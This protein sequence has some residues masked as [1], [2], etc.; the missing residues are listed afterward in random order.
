MKIALFLSLLTLTA[1]AAC[2]D[3]TATTQPTNNCVGANC[4][5]PCTDTS[6]CPAETFCDDDG[7]CQ[8]QICAPLS[9]GC[10]GNFVVT[11]NETGSAL[12]DPTACDNGT[13]IAG[14]C[15]CI[16]DTDCGEGERCDTVELCEGEDCQTRSF[17]RIACE[18]NV[19]GF[20]GE[21]CCTGD[22]PTCGPAGE[23]APDCG[24]A[25]LCGEDF[26]QCCDPGDVCI[27]GACK[28]PGI[29][30]Q[31]FLE[32]SW[33]E[34]CD[35]GLQRCLPDDFPEE[36][37]CRLEGDFR[38]FQVDE[39]WS[40][41]DGDIIS[42]PVVGDVT[43]DGVPNIVVN[44]TVVNDWGTGQIVI[45]DSAGNLVREIAHDPMA[46]S[47]GSF[48]RSNIALGDVDGDGVL[49][50]IYPGRH[51]NAGKGP[52]VA[53][54][55]LGDLLWTSKDTLGATV[56]VSMGN[57]AVT[58]AN[59]D[60]DASRTEVVVG[61]ML[62]DS[63]GVVQWNETGNGPSLGSNSGYFGGIAVVADLDADGQHEIIT[64]RQAW[65]VIENAGTFSVTPFWTS[66][67]GDGYPA[68]AD[69]DG[70]GKPEVVLVSAGTVRILNG[71]TGLPWC[72]AGQDCGANPALLTQ[73][74]A[75]PGAP[76]NNR[77]GPPT[78]ADFDGD[79]RPEIG[80][81]GGYFYS[82][83]DVARAG[84]AGTTDP[85]E[86]D[87]A[88]L[89]QFETPAPELNQLFVRW[90]RASQDLSSNATGSSV[91]DFQGNGIASVIYADECYMRSF[92]GVD[93]T[94]ELEIMNSTATVLEYPL[95]VDIDAD[96]RSEILIVANAASNCTAIPD[97]VPRR[98]LYVYEDA[99]DRWVR[100]RA[101]WNQ[102]AYSIDNILDSG[103]VPLTQVESWTTHNTFRSNRQGEI[104]LNAPDVVV[105]SL[106]GNANECPTHIYLQ[107]TVQNRGTSS[108]PTGLP[109][110]LY[111]NDTSTLLETKALTSPL[112]PGGT[113]IVKFSYLVPSSQFYKD[114]KFI[115]VANDAGDGT[116]FVED[117][118][119]ATGSASIDGLRCELPL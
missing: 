110:S 44:T 103:A 82:V 42:I 117:C 16:A 39:K 38:E 4:V 29:T 28:T 27:F 11:C 55:G 22:T 9:T 24:Q 19:C 62:L 17:C 12:V 52:I 119:T 102:H 65:K 106:L 95:V 80:V 60:A 63:N 34:Y 77:G 69:F 57:G 3:D 14:G 90:K 109:V 66:V 53:I 32:C 105:S 45:L 64:G 75:L 99:F 1:L 20:A 115:V 43:G 91:F 79:G 93:G 114:L 7:I 97:Y 58:V 70:D 74:I 5:L 100:T 31:S 92:S 94:V 15:G 30:C 40:W 89:A 87:P 48:G 50:I 86:I 61:G 51:I 111:F 104:P 47:W 84:Y 18:G 36:I 118:D 76:E 101:I 88:L 35:P 71:Q 81:A 83:F 21:L 59:F 49:D 33:G 78:V 68:V 98:G 67:A 23:C 25:Q 2:S 13:C 6:E 56:N 54:N 26:D 113:V 37:E 10:Q 107:A 72:A 116:T 85:E 108:I 46:G 8:D 96:G 73:P 41:T 112:A